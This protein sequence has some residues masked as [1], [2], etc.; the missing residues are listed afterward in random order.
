MPQCPT[1]AFYDASTTNLGSVVSWNWSFGDGNTSSTQNPQHTYAVNGNYQVCLVI[2]TSSGCVNTYCDTINITC[3]QPQTCQA[4]F[5]YT[6]CPDVYFFDASTTNVGSIVGWTWDFGDGASSTQQ[7]PQHTYTANGWYQVCL[8]IQTSGGCFSTYCDSVNINCIQPANCNA[9]FTQTSN[10][11]LLTTFTD[12]STSSAGPIVSWIWDFGDGG[13]STQQNP[14]HLYANPGYYYVCLTII[15]GGAQ[16]C[17]SVTCDTITVG[18]VALE[19]A[20]PFTDLL[21]TPNPFED[22]FNVSYTLTD[23]EN[24][25]LVLY[26]ALGKKVR[27]LDVASHGIGTHQLSVSAA[28]LS[29]GLYLLRLSSPAG[30]KTLHILHR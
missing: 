15:T 10:P 22:N 16:P 11:N 28:D 3:I 27:V 12:V 6:Q 9:A 26:D 7:N 19:E 5:G 21:V 29:A 14:T 17:T 13:N 24:I 25:E 23:R 20:L 1:V 18:T 4:N 2:Q 30:S 8:I